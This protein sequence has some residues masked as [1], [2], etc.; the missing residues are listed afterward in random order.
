MTSGFITILEGPDGAGKTT[1]AKAYARTH[2]GV[3]VIHLG[4]H[5]GDPFEELVQHLANN[6]GPVVFDRFHIGEQTYGPVYR[7][8]DGLGQYGRTRIERLLRER[9]AIVVLALPPY[10]ICFGNWEARKK[11]GGEMFPDP[12]KYVK[13]YDRYKAVKTT[14]PTLQYDYTWH[15]NAAA[16]AAQAID[17]VRRDAYFGGKS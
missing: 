2:P 6:P 3:R 4:P 12:S 17:D 13:L 16:M 9:Q 15:R 14:L 11:A 8:R 7:G 1:L 5:V 10:E